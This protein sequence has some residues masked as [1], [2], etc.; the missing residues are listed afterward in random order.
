[1]KITKIKKLKN[2][3][4]E[5]S[6]A[7]DDKTEVF[8]LSE[9]YLIQYHL[10]NNK[11]LSD[12]EYQEINTLANKSK[13]YHKTLNYLSYKMR[14]EGEI[15]AYLEK[16]NCCEPTITEII[17]R[18]KKLNYLNDK[19]YSDLYVKQQ[20]DVNKKGPLLIKKKLL[21]KDIKEGIIKKS[22]EYIN[23]EKINNNI[24]SLISYFDRLNKKKTINQLK[25]TIFRNLLSK[26]Y[27]Y[28]DI[29]SC[30]NNFSFKINR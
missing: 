16:N 1:M 21:A 18:L 6:I 20:F 13:I 26:G 24:N 22:L 7:C 19:V 23:D 2:N 10:Y 9:D 3:F 29:F 5:L 27:N 17:N 30:I 25:K 8:K 28:D 11:E 12:K 14:T 15:K 4:Y